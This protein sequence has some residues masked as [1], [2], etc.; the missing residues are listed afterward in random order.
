MKKIKLIK[1]WM[2]LWDDGSWKVTPFKPKKEEW[3]DDV[4]DFQIIRVLITP[5]TKKK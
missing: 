5:L 2:T 4:G 1:A 3:W